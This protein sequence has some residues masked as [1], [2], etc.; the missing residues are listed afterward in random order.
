[1]L[2]IDKTVFLTFSRGFPVT[3]GEVVYFFTN[4]FGVDSIKTIRMGNAKSS[5]QVMFA[6]M[7]LNCVETLDRILNGGRIAK[8]CVNGKQ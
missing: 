3:K 2:D 1:V 4:T 6:T 7:V 8:Y 5:H